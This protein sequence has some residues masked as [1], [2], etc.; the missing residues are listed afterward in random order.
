MWKIDKILISILSAATLLYGCVSS[1]IPFRFDRDVTPVFLKKTLETLKISEDKEG[2]DSLEWLPLPSDLSGTAHIYHTK[3]IEGG[4]EQDN[5]INLAVLNK[6][7]ENEFVSYNAG[8]KH[9]YNTY[10]I[11]FKLKNSTTRKPFLFFTVQS[12]A[13]TNNTV[14]GF[15]KIYA[16]DLAL[17]TR[18]YL[19][20]A[21]RIFSIEKRQTDF[22]TKMARK[23]DIKFLLDRNPDISKLDSVQ[24]TKIALSYENELSGNKTMEIPV[25]K[26]MGGS[27]SLLLR[28]FIKGAAGAKTQFAEIKID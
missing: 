4:M 14:I 17:N 16:G 25:D 5:F 2:R 6:D 3:F 13:G 26:V 20:S 28:S 22:Y 12:I 21:T 11:L 9:I 24:I 1:R 10:L 15:S 27:A 7:R 8:S 18:T 23:T 19:L